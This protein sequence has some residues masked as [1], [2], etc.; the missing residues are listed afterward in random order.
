MAEWLCS[1]LQN[2]VHR[3]NSGPGLHF[4]FLTGHKPLPQETDSTYPSPVRTGCIEA[5]GIPGIALSGTA[6]GFGAIAR[7]AGFD[8]FQTTASTFLIWGMPGQVAMASLYAGGSSLFVIFTAV[9]LAN[10]RMML[11]SIS[12]ADM[13][14]LNRQDLPFLKRLFYIQFLAISGWAQLTYR[15]AQYSKAE[16]RQYY[17]GFTV[18]LFIMA[19]GGTMIGFMLDDLV[20]AHI[21]PLIIFVTPIYILL[22]LVNAKQTVNRWAGCFGGVIGPLLYPVFSD[23]AIF[24]AGFVGACLAVLMMTYRQADSNKEA[25]K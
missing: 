9:A 7:E 5:C 15:E 3:F 14:G 11:M 21:K 1:G 4:I 17:I 13:L 20:P 19:L 25:G 18:I 23:W 10:L 24:V 8:F 16:L 12:G 22:L 6:I 2:R